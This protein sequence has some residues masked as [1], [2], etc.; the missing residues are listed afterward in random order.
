MR[1]LFAKDALRPERGHT[2]GCLLSSSAEES[3]YWVVQCDSLVDP[4]SSELAP[5][6]VALEYL[7]ALEGPFWRKIRGKGYSY[8]YSVSHSLE[9][10]TLKFALSKAT[11]PIAAYNIAGDI[12]RQLCAEGGDVQAAAEGVEADDEEVVDEGLDLAAIEAA[13]SGVIFGLIEPVDTIPGAMGEA[14]DNMLRREPPDQLQWLLKAVQ[15]VTEESVRTALRTHILPLFTGACGRIVS[16]VCPAQKRE[17]I[18]KGLRELDPP[19]DVVHF[20]VEAFVGAMAP[21]TGFADL[22]SRVLSQAKAGK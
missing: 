17:E 3:N 18:E 11:N 2:S 19:F 13:Q 9:T 21:A 16:I 5:L 20:D 14:F 22:R 8:S 15:G 1:E 12:V 10:G 6:L 7:T 4:R